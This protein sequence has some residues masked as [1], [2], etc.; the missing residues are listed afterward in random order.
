MAKSMISQNRRSRRARK[1]DKKRRDRD[2]QCKF[3]DPMTI[4]MPQ[5]NPLTSTK[6]LQDT[7]ERV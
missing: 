3:I 2:V 4:L 7:M 5:N 1:Q 6:V